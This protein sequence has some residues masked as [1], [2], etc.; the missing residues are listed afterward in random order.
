MKKTLTI[1]LAV[2]MAAAVISIPVI[3][4][5]QTTTLTTTVPEAE[6]TMTVPETLEIEF[7]TLTKVIGNVTAD[8]V[9]GFNVGKNV[10]VTVTHDDLASEG[11]ST[12]IPYTLSA[13]INEAIENLTSYQDNDTD[14]VLLFKTLSDMEFETVRSNGTTATDGKYGYSLTATFSAA[15]WGKALAGDYTT[16]ITFVAEIVAAE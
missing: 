9:S 15:D 14:N 11:K 2:L 8:A 7:G 4:D 16:T 13:C 5:T 3:A 6:Y 12:K 1:L 10:Q